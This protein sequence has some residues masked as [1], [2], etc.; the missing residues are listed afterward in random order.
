MT[1]ENRAKAAELL[2]KVAEEVRNLN[3]SV[4]VL[5]KKGSVINLRNLRKQMQAEKEM[6]SR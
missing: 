5:E 2:R 3:T 6:L 4:T 1:E